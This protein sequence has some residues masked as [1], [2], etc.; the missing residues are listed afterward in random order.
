MKLIGQIFIRLKAASDNLEMHEVKEILTFN[1]NL[2]WKSDQITLSQR[3]T[4]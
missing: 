1:Q 3:A 4:Y 2:S